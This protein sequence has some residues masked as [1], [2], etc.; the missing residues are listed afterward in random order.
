MKTFYGLIFIIIICLLTACEHKELCFVHTHT[1]ELQVIFDWKYA[2]KAHPASMRLYLF[3]ET[4][5]EP[6]IYEFGNRTGGKITV[7]A[8]R[9]RA[10]CM[11]NDTEFI[12]IRNTDHYESIEA[13]LAD[14]VFPRPVPRAGS[15]GEQR[16]KSTPDMLWSDHIEEVEVIASAEGQT[17]TLYPKAIVRHYTV[18]IR[19][20]ENL[21]YLT[22]G[23]LFG[24]LTDMSDGFMLGTNQPAEELATL[25][26]EM[27]SDGKSTV[28]ADFYTF[29]YPATSTN[30]QYLTVYAILNDGKK[31]SFTYDVT[32]KIHNAPDPANVHILLDGLPL[33]KP[34]D[35]GGGFNPDVDEWSTVEI[36]ISM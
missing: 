13:Y 31:Y 18:E 11:N 29:G 1:A 10:L 30:T 17:L 25:P 27:T 36:S 22:E 4:G 9:Y 12:I 32:E 8:G 5:K 2:P 7:P 35:N 14:G 34:I 15:T 23:E 26:F 28:N 16:V 33:P 19:N 3:P 6:L 21:K 20:V 24:S